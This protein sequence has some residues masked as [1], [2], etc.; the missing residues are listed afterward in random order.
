[1]PKPFGSL[2]VAVHVVQVGQTQ[3]RKQAVWSLRERD[4]VGANQ[5]RRFTGLPRELGKLAPGPP[6][7]EERPVTWAREL[8]A[9]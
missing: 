7:A 9:S 5:S 6:V 2:R 8:M 1:L 4:F 3:L